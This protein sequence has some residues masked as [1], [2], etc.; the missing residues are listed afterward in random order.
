MIDRTE[1]TTS[2]VVL[3]A[4]TCGWFYQPVSFY[5]GGDDKTILRS[6]TCS[7]L[8][9]HPKG[10]VLFDTGFSV[11][12]RALLNQDL[13]PQEQG[14][15]FP[16]G[17]DIEAQLKAIGVDSDDVKWIINSHLH[18]DH[19]GGN[20]VAKNATVI[21]QEREIEA[22]KQA[23]SEPEGSRARMLYDPSLYE[24]GQAVLAIDGELD[25]FGDGAIVIVPT[26]GHTP[27]HQSARVRLP[28]GDVLLTGDCCNLERSL[29]ELLVSPLD[30]DA[31]QSLSTLRFLAAE[32]E[33]GS[34][35]FPG[36]DGHFWQH[37]PQAT[38]LT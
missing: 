25:L 10:L 37:I 15:E 8:I 19:C 31:E 33:R 12:S 22:A 5:L 1:R 23:T 35:I 30:A 14:F 20:A 32:R 27:G 7:Y 34:R 21:L 28:A 2:P 6:P 16:V 4:F 18:V 13:T 3:R 24:T 36:H 17:T 38:P 29:D 11:R 9:E 26:Y